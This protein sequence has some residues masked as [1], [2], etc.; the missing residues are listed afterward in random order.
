MG[1]VTSYVTWDQM[2]QLGIFM[3]SS[4]TLIYMIFHDHNKK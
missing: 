2:I 4:L 1:N 3:T